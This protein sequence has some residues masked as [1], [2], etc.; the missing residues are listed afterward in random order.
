M[1]NTC[2]PC[3][4]QQT[5]A[6]RNYT[7]RGLVVAYQVFPHNVEWYVAIYI[8]CLL[9]SYRT[10]AQ[11]CDE[12]GAFLQA[13]SDSRPLPT[14]PSQDDR[15][16]HD[17]TPFEDRIAFDWASYHYEHLQSSAA[18]IAEGLNLWSAISIK[19]GSTAG[20]PWR[21]AKDMYATIDSIRT[22]SLPFKSFTF[23]YGGPKPSSPPQWM[24][25]VY[26][27]NAR[28]ALEVVREQLATQDFNNQFNY[29]PY[30]EFNG[31]GERVWSHLMS[32]HWA[33]MQAVRPFSPVLL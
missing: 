20:A 15:R 26:E 16:V 21:N 4:T 9:V 30:K 25:Q 33:F 14:L 12:G 19:H 32:G 13:P 24:E 5:Q 31:K 6:S 11:P 10:T 3:S 8:A 18:E 2:W 29:A 28:D 17:W 23:R 27:L 22:G 7:S 1:L